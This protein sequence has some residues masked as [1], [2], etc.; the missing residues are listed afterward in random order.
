MA[1]RKK[2]TLHSS[3][4]PRSSSPRLAAQSE[5][6]L[7]SAADEAHVDGHS[8]FLED[9]WRQSRSGA[10]AG[11]GYHYQDAVGAW[12]AIRVHVGDLD[13]D[14]IIPEG[15]EDMTCGGQNGWHV[16]VKSRQSRVGDFPLGEATTDVLRA[17]N[18]HRARRKRGL[19]ERLA[20][21]FERPVDGEAS[22]TW[23]TTLDQGAGWVGLAQA[24][25]AKASSDGIS[26]TEVELMLAETCVI[27]LP[28]RE[29]Y[30]SS[31]ARIAASAG[32]TAKAAEVVVNRLKSA[33]ADHADRNAQPDWHHRS[34]LSRTE[35]DRLVLDAVA[36]VDHG[37]LEEA[38]RTGCC[39]PIDFDSTISGEQYYEGVNTQPGHVAAGLV[40][41]RPALTGLILDAL[42]TGRAALVVGPSG[43]GKSA[44]VWSAAYVARHVRWYRIRRLLSDDVEPLRRLAR[45]AGAGKFA[46]VGFVVDGVGIGPLHGWDDLCRTVTDQPGVVLLGSCR[47]EDLLPLATLSECKVIHARLDESVAERIHAGL[48]GRRATSET[49]WREAFEQ[50]KGLTLEFTHLLTNGRRLSEVVGDQIRT[51]VREHRGLELDVLAPI[52]FAHQW[53]GSLDLEQ[54]E[55]HTRGHD[56]HLRAALTR[57][58]DEHLIVVADG[59]VAGLHQLRSAALSDAVHAHPPPLVSVTVRTVIRTIRGRDLAGFLASMLSNLPDLSKV[60]TDELANA[61]ADG[62]W[63]GRLADALDGMRAADFVNTAKHWRATLAAH[64]VPGPIASLTVQ[65]ALL[66]TELPDAL[67]PRVVAAAT[68]IRADALQ[69]KSPLRDAL[70]AA[71]G[72]KRIALEVYRC[73]SPNELVDLLACLARAEIGDEMVDALT[74]SEGIIESAPIETLGSLIQAG[75]DVNANCAQA[76]VAAAGGEEVIVSRLVASDPMVIDLGLAHD[77]NEQVLRGRRVHISDR[78]NSAPERTIKD[79]A[80]LGLR[81]LPMV[82]RADLTTVWVGGSRAEAR[83]RDVGTSGLLRQY[84]HG[85]TE[86]DWNQA[87]CRAVDTLLA[88]DTRTTRLNAGRAVLQQ[89]AAFLQDLA[90]TWV[91]SRN[92]TSAIDRLNRASSALIAGLDALPPTAPAEESALPSDPI[93]GI[94]KAIATNLRPRLGEGATPDLLAAFVRDTI[95]RDVTNAC[96]EPWYLLGLCEPPAEL[97]QLRRTLSDLYVVLAELAWGGASPRLIASVARTSSRRIALAQVARSAKEWAY[98]RQDAAL[99]EVCEGIRQSGFG[100]TAVTVEDDELPATTWPQRQVALLV[101]LITLKDLNEAWSAVAQLVPTDTVHLHEVTFLPVLG[102]RLLKQ[103]AATIIGPGKIYPGAVDL[104]RWKQKLP[105]SHPTPLLDSVSTAH[106]AL[107]E[108]SG[109][110]YLN[111]CR[112]PGAPIDAAAEVATVE[113]HS[114][115]DRIRALPHDP[116]TVAIVEELARIETRVQ[117][118]LS[119]D[120]HPAWYS[121]AIAHGL[122]VS[123]DESH[124]LDALVLLSAQW[125]VD[126]EIAITMLV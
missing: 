126:R 120:D 108:L 106:G 83:G 109:I 10:I 87:R 50:S 101:E 110:A 48:V 21:V 102:G 115:F 100:V 2:R 114:A 16:Q 63:S 32:V 37:A 124:M 98:G 46:T 123:N 9:A 62:R 86:L 84:V 59:A 49:H 66:G 25:R 11:R 45:A 52:A 74:A 28:W 105:P 94:A 12:L 64:K 99:E 56:A 27:V 93:H 104:H 112:A 40:V 125:D 60:V 97:E 81:C 103:G 89:T 47:E 55:A 8:S 36:T 41:P 13:V 26:Q 58:L 18:S 14:E 117:I 38:I 121:S 42:D 92:Q 85:P 68:E 20:V 73:S 23:G 34:V 35:I 79:F 24:L 51:R 78:L 29:I 67:D 118:E 54:L 119:A 44:V 39:E 80:M 7:L 95:L 76:L 116:V 69:T 17:W 5:P 3:A 53:G 90:S 70:V 31:A 22:V 82:A 19:P 72:A 43:V 88:D 6:Q 107:A 57:L 4:R 75:A 111:T 33:I 30:A 71:V 61:V 65:L 122:N 96:Q 15:F 1:G 113:L 91:I 77:G